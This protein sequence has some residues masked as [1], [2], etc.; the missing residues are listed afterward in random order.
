MGPY[1]VSGSAPH[2]TRPLP[3]YSPS[4]GSPCTGNKFTSPQPSYIAPEIVMCQFKAYSHFNVSLTSDTVV[5]VRTSVQHGKIVGELSSQD[6]LS[7]P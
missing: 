3:L 1:V 2:K 5:Q 6:N 7:L 4:L